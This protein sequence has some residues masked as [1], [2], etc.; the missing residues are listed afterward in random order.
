VQTIWIDGVQLSSVTGMVFSGGSMEWT[1]MTT[2]A[3][4]AVYSGTQSS[5]TYV[6]FD[7]YYIA[8]K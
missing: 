7:D 6:D 1:G 8:V 3:A 2:Y 4:R 5:T